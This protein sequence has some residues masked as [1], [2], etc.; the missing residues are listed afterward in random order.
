MGRH[1]MF[2][3]LGRSGNFCGRAGNFILVRRP[4]FESAK[5]RSAIPENGGRP[6][7][8]LNNRAEDFGTDACYFLFFR[9]SASWRPPACARC[10]VVRTQLLSPYRMSDREIT[11]AITGLEQVIIRLETGR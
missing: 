5:Q 4:I 2:S 6:F 1:A 3:L 11:G 8:G 10:F 7:S 9:G